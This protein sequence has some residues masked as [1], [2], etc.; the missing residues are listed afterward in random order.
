MLRKIFGSKS[1]EATGEWR[2]L[3]NEEVYCLC[4]AQNTTRKKKEMGG[5]CSMCRKKGEVYTAFWW[6]NLR[7]RDHLED[8]GADGMTILRWIFR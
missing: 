1:D 3:H 2:G 7:E 8:P 6:E 4:S 5:A